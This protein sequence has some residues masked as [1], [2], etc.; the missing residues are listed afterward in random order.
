MPVMLKLDQA[1]ALMKIMARAKCEIIININSH[2]TNYE[3]VQ[4]YFETLESF[5]P[6]DP[7]VRE[8][9][10]GGMV[11]LD[12]ICEIMVYP[13]TPIGSHSVY[14]WDLGTAIEEMHAILFDDEANP[15]A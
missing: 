13:D 7:I 3:S 5:N 1:H 2:R 4:S 8:D 15:N 10:L 9:V 6:D 14:H 12:T 11:N